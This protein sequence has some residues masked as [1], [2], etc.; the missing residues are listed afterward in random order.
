MRIIRAVAGAAA[1]ETELV[2]AMA[3]IEHGAVVRAPDGAP[4][5]GPHEPCPLVELPPVTDGGLPCAVHLRP[6]VGVVYYVPAVG[7]QVRALVDRAAAG[8]ERVGEAHLQA[9][10]AV[11]ATPFTALRHRGRVVGGTLV[12]GPRPCFKK[13]VGERTG[14][15]ARILL[16]VPPPGPDGFE[17]PP[18]FSVRAA[19]TWVFMPITAAV[20]ICKNG[21][22]GMDEVNALV[23]AVFYDV[24]A[25]SRFGHGDV[26]LRVDA[27][28]LE[29]A[30]RPAWL[31]DLA[32]ATARGVF[33]VEAGALSFVGDKDAL[34]GPGPIGARLPPEEAWNPGALAGEAPYRCLYCGV[35]ASG[36]MVVLRDPRGPGTRAALAAHPGEAPAGTQGRP[37]GALLPPQFAGKGLLLCLPCWGALDSPACLERHLHAGV[38]RVR[39]PLSQ[40]DACAACAGYW[41][42]AALLRG[43][44]RPAAG[45]PGAF[46]V[47]T[48]GDRPAYGAEVVIASEELGPHPLLSYPALAALRLPVVPGLRIAEVVAGPAPAGGR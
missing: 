7:L 43:R 6:T 15:P 26:V 47:A 4:L 31:N 8:L 28:D 17:A 39:V 24:P 40:A 2:A 38:T 20:A 44:A 12:V 46:V 41:G 23:A 13:P 25:V 36:E 48:A 18:H 34:G 33:V 16:F 27:R 9:P 29:G 5:P 10:R 19:F 1:A 32:T 14:F 11:A 21:F 30:E 3:N 35:P 42:V 37:G 22:R 45:V